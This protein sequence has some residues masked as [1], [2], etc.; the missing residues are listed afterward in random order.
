MKKTTKTKKATP[1]AKE[2]PSEDNYYTKEEEKRLDKFHELTERKFDDEEIYSLRMKYK[3]DDDAIL[4]DLKEQ[5]KEE[6]RGEGAW[7]EVGKSNYIFFN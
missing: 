5:L 1:K 2:K 3:D 4:N 6:K 7:E